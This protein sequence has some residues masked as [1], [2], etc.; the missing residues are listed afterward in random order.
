MDDERLGA[1][2]KEKCVTKKRIT[3]MTINY[4]IPQ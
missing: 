3:I 2:H 4:N 1:C